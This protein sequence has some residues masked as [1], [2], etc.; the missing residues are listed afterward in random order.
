MLVLPLVSVLASVPCEP[1]A[2]ALRPLA[3]R[4]PLQLVGWAGGQ[5]VAVGSDWRFYAVDV[6][7]HEVR[8][9]GDAT[10][11]FRKPKNARS[12]SG[13][14]GPNGLSI[15][16]GQLLDGGD[17]PVRA[18]EPVLRAAIEGWPRLAPVGASPSR[19]ARSERDEWL[20]VTSEPSRVF[21]GRGRLLTEHPIQWLGMGLAGGDMSITLAIDG[22]LV[23]WEF[24]PPTRYAP[25]GDTSLVRFFYDPKPVR[26]RV[27]N[28][29]V[30]EQ[31]DVRATERPAGHRFRCLS[32]PPAERW[33]PDRG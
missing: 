11:L 6:F 2:T 26:V 31:R 16:N 25:S 10:G 12:G 29:L 18:V 4:D 27:G 21:F 15:W 30:Q 22:R 24:L 17:E 5:L 7:A 9:L 14:S 23:S 3:R 13:R 1:F 28:Q 19:I 33:W 32:P 8:W 20:I